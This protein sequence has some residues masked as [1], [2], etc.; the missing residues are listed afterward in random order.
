MWRRYIGVVLF[1]AFVLVA[2]ARM[3]AQVWT[4]LAFDPRDD[5]RD[6]LLA[7]AEQLSYRYDKEQDRLWFRVSL[8]GKPNAESFGVNI[9]VDTGADDAAKMN[10][11]GANKDFRFDKLITAWV[12]KN[13]GSYQGT[14]GVGDAAGARAK[15]INNLLQNNLQIQVEGDSILVGL[16]RADLTDRMKVNLIAAV[17]SRQEWND[18]IPDMRSATLDL[19][20]PRP[21]RGLR[22][23]DVS[24]NNLRFS[25][26]YKPL[27][28]SQPPLIIKKGRGRQT[29]ILIPGVYSGSTAFDG[30]IA[31]N[32]AQYKFYVI[33]PPGLNGTPA[34]PLPP[35]TSSYGDFTWTR[36]LER[37]ILDLISREKLDK[38]VIVAH[39]FPGCLAAHE[40]AIRRPEVLGGVI[41][42]AVMPVQFFPSPKDP[43]RKTPATPD[44][45]V[46]V[47][48]ESWVEK[49]FKYVTPETWETNNYPAEMF[50]NDLDR[51]E[52][53]RQQVETAPLPVKVRYLAEFMA[54][55]DT[56]R[57]A[58][59]R[60][61]LLALRPGFNEKL[62]ADPANSWYKA[63]FQDSWDAFSR[64]SRIQ[65]VTIPN[66]RA[67]VLDDQPK[68]ADAAIATF[69]ETSKP[70]QE[71]MKGQLLE[72]EDVNM[73]ISGELLSPQDLGQTDGDFPFPQIMVAVAL[74]LI[75]EG[76]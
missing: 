67:L 14:I 35:E 63:S 43:S 72:S 61:P 56:S 62:L 31:R 47:V 39:G 33:T 45:R 30:F 59:L 13:N 5:V 34:R 41:D 57:L 18:D 23:I 60:V 55:D 76:T 17:G 4:V 19:A 11:W 27:A 58:N 64:N 44:E 16:K 51:A 8:F 38:P 2:P 75:A 1:L 70:P 26:D 42:L 24:R 50:A 66:A 20:A 25:S 21:T 68:L 65:S 6:P 3:M 48:N 9:V 32:Q 73:G 29:L 49:W 36:R 7:D 15:K 40:L 28:D 69:V 74:L 22:E 52:Q 37:D 53:V 10:W 46:K 54:S 12:V 71:S